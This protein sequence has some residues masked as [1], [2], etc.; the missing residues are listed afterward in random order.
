MNKPITHK[1]KIH[2]L[3]PEVPFRTK[4]FIDDKDI[5]STGFRISQQV[6]DIPHMEI[7][8]MPE[9][10]NN[11]D[12]CVVEFGNID[13]IANIISRNQLLSLIRQFNENDKYEKIEVEEVDK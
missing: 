11:F 13:A 7:D 12:S 8:I 4:I 3:D 6:G 9:I 5:R 10:D 2:S 1:V